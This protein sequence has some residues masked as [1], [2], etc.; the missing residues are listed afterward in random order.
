MVLNA[1]PSAAAE[2]EL[3]ALMHPEQDINASPGPVRW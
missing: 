2:V 1:Q 3:P